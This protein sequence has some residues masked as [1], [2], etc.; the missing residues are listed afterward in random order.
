MVIAII[1][2]VIMAALAAYF[3]WTIWAAY[4][5]ARRERVER[6]RR[7]RVIHQAEYQIHTKASEAFRNMMR[8]AREKSG[9]C[10]G[11]R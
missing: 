7:T 1:V 10:E 8:V 6:A 11:H 9:G 2:L 5:E 3:A 4:A